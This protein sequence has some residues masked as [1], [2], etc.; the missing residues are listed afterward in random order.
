MMDQSRRWAWPLQAGNGWDATRESTTPSS[1]VAV[2]A[3]SFLVKNARHGHC[4]FSSD[5]YGV[6]M[7]ESEPLDRNHRRHA[8]RDELVTLKR[9]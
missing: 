7:V 5:L 2:N 1:N 6:K 3:T 8:T 4:R 9:V